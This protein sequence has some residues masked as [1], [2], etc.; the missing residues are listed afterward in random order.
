MKNTLPTRG[1]LE[2]QLSQT[3][4]SLYRHKFGHSPSKITCHIFGDKV[5]IV[6][7]DTVTM[8]EKVLFENSKLDL[9]SSIRSTISKVF[10]VEVKQI[11]ADI[12]Q[13]QAVDIIADSTISTGYL[14]MI[15]FLDRPPVIRITKKRNRI[16]SKHIETSSDR[17]EDQINDN[18]AYAKEYGMD[19]PEISNWT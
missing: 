18:L 15:V 10:T 3:L 11:I 13:V 7:E 19:Q 12:L 2:R 14:G 6:A 5:A 8:V 1:Q 17:M 9:A 4:Q 16:M